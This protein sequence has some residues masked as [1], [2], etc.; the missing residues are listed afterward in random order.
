[1]N[2]RALLGSATV[3]VTAVG[4]WLRA[5]PQAFASAR[6]TPESGQ[7]PIWRFE[8]VAEYPHDPNAYTQG[9]VF[10]GDGFFEGTGQYG[11]S[12]L[13]ETALETGEVLRQQDLTEDY[14][15]EGIALVDDRIYQ[16][17]WREETAFLYQKDTFEPIGEFSYAGEG[18]G[19]TWSG[20]HL[21]MSDGSSTIVFRDPESF[22]I[23][24]QI[25]V[26]AGDLAIDN[27]NELEWIDNEIWANI[28]QTDWIARIDPD[29]GKLTSWVDLQGLLPLLPGQGMPGVLNGIAWD[30]EADRLFVTGKYWPTLF[31]IRLV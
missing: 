28:Y 25:E 2:R 17:T 6:F 19:L 23:V 18:W 24:R 27:L 20:E 15:G 11:D 5:D 26:H 16:I 12:D 10:I 14:F 21:V 9:L 30:A 22:E 29:S 13:R 4:A 3:G 8:V 31:E 7:E 1:M